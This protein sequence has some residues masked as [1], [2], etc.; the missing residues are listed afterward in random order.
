M[1]AIINNKGEVREM[2][3]MKLLKNRFA[4]CRLNNKELIPNWVKEDEF[5]L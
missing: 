1:Q 5:F 2:L 3:T 4:V